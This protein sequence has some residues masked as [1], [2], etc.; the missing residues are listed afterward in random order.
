VSFRPDAV[1]GAES[2]QSGS[3]DYR[4]ARRHLLAE[5][6]R[7]R[8]SRQD[9]CDAHPELIRAARHVGEA[10]EDAC[11]ICEEEHM[12]VVSYVFGEGLPAFGRCI[13]T[14]AELQKL[15]RQVGQFACYVVEV[16][17]ICRWNHLARTYRLGRTRGR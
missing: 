1:R 2:A 5:Y 4:L 12:V 10:T 6:K 17:P 13:S 15:A 16:C 8:L 3:V 7:G 11:P 14:K 9:L